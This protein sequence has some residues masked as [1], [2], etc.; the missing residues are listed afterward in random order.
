M[1]LTKTELE[2]IKSGEL[3]L[4]FR[5]WRRPTVKTAGSLKTAIGVLGIERVV[6]IERSQI[7]ERDAA[8]AGYSSLSELLSKLDSREGE[9]YRIEIRFAGA[10]PRIELRENDRL[11]KSDF[12]EVQAKL[13]R[14][15]S[16]SRMGDWTRMVLRAID[17][18]PHVAAAKLAGHTGFEKEWLKQNIRKLKNLGLTT[19]HEPGYEL[20]PRGRAVLNHLEDDA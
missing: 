8:K 10:D 9:I 12:H 6:K 20:S 17:Q 11:S 14:L 19:S 15:D 16:A 7:T 5:H 3:S 2:A 18:H 1:L 13:A 4:V